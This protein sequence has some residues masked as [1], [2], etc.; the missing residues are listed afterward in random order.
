MSKTLPY[1]F[2]TANLQPVRKAGSKPKTVLSLIGFV[3]KRCS[4]LSWKVKIALLSA[5][6][7]N[8]VRI[9]LSTLGKIS[10]FKESLMASFTSS[11]T[12]ESLF[13]IIFSSSK[14]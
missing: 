3:I 9:S 13:L 12:K 7:V 14:P 1:G 4:K 11:T 6:S 10:R 2:K 5:F 8:S